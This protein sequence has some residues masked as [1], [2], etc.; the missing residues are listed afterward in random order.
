MRDT[1]TI[2]LREDLKK[3]LDAL[4]KREGLTRSDLVRESLRS[5]LAIRKFHELRLRLTAKAKAKGIF[6]DEDVFERV[7]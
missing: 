3:E 5:F 1:I 7:S 4:I 2:S 6:T